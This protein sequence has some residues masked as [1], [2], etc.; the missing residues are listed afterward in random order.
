MQMTERQYKEMNERLYA[1]KKE[2]S[3]ALIALHD[4]AEAGDLRENA[5]YESSRQEVERLSR[6]IGK[7]ESDLASAEIILENKSPRFTI[8]SLI[9]VTRL[10]AD[11]SSAGPTRRFRLDANGNTI[12][13]GVLGIKSSLGQAIYNGTDGIY[14]IPDNGGIDY[15]VK[16]VLYE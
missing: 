3:E 2:Y 11:G 6:S 1:E 13:M 14:T 10:N 5:E 16:K 4:A 8:G 12:I 15:L 9:D 7:L